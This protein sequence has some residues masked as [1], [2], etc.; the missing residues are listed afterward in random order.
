LRSLLG[1]RG[2]E[3]L[4]GARSSTTEGCGRLSAYGVVVSTDRSFLA[5]RPALVAVAFSAC[6]VSRR[7]LALA[8]QPPGGSR[9][10][11]AYGPVV[12]ADR[13]F[14]DHL[15]VP[16]RRTRRRWWSPSTGCTHADFEDA[17]D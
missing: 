13:S 2:F 5:A 17:G 15:S 4:A 9:C 10:F 1:V 14:L 11:S 8:P 3:T 6:V 12:S 16:G 7:S